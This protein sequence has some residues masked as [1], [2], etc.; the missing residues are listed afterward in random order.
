MA[1]L[2]IRNVQKTFRTYAK[3]GLFHRPGAR[4][5]ASELPVL[6]GVD[7]TVEKGD[8]VAI[9]GPSGSG[10]TTLLRCLNFLETADAGQLVFDGESFD[11]AHA[12]RADIAR[13]RKKTAFVF[14]N[15][16]LFRNKTAL[17]NVT[18]GLIVARKLPKEQADAI[19][20]KM[21]AKVGLADRADYY[22]RQLSGG[23][24]QRVAIARGLA[25][26]PEIILFDEP[27]S[28]LD[29]SMIGEVQSVI[30][31]LAKS[32]R[33]MMIVTH[34]MDFARKVANRVLFMDEGGIYEEGTPKEIFEHPK[35]EKTRRFIQ[36][37]SSLIYR[38][39]G[40][41]FD[42]EAMNEELQGYGEKL[43]IES[44]RLSK[45]SLAI[46]EICINTI[47]DYSE[48][49]DIIVKVE[50]SE[51]KDILSL[52]ITYKGP[53]FDVRDTDSELFKELLSEP[54][55]SYSEKTVDDPD[56]FVNRIDMSF[57]WVEE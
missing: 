37:L 6:R 46:E 1:M 12:S 22:P 29:P 17:Q 42:I 35:R 44:E 4:K 34:E 36:R 24:Q 30:K 50:Y 16:N 51:K 20:M 23:Q 31:L 19:G 33:T 3:P 49:P 7:L 27:T 45:L 28:A 25:T 5:A 2:E 41:D 26:D 10:K 18:E 15:Y 21:L 9:L 53:Y 48:N 55:T 13:L 43:L 40:I 52:I 57:K 8:V 38:I 54:T 14:Q 56:G 47:A 39:Q 11:L 32:G